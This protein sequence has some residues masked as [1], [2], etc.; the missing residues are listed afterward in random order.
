MVE[1]VCLAP[2]NNPRGSRRIVYR[3]EPTGL[4]VFA[5]FEAGRLTLTAAREVMRGLSVCNFFS[6][7][8]RFIKHL[9]ITSQYLRPIIQA[10]QL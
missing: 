6:V 2:H 8:G 9:L 5:V 10:F 3:E 4:V 7:T 1:V